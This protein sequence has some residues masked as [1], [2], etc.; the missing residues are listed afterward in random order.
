M[1]KSGGSGVLRSIRNWLFISRG[2]HETRG[3]FKDRLQYLFQPPDLTTDQPPADQLWRFE[4]TAGP[5]HLVFMDTGE[6]DGPETPE[7]SY[8]QPKFWQAYRQRDAAWLK[9]RVAARGWGNRPWRIFISHI[10]L[11]NPAGWFSIGSRDAR[12]SDPNQT[13]NPKLEE[14]WTLDLPLNLNPK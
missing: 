12:Q 13:R 5:A 14:V 11:H 7:D 9:E 10:P 4:L 3:G 1:N 8:K 6:D 2:N